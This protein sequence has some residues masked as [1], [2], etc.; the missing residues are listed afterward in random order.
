MQT[1]MPVIP[2]RR[3]GTDPEASTQPRRQG[4]LHFSKWRVWGRG[5]FQRT[6]SGVALK[7]Q[8]MNCGI[9]PGESVE[10]KTAELQA[11][12]DDVSSFVFAIQFN[13]ILKD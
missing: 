1:K 5:C 7:F 8:L 10:Q 2:A 4:L 3:S 11:T 12:R 9:L 13:F 6:K